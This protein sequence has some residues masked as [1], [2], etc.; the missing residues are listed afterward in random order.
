MWKKGG[1]EL[2]GA[3]DMRVWGWVTDV[4]GCMLW[5]GVGYVCK[6][7]GRMNG[8]LYLKILDDELQETITYYNKTKDDIIFQQDNDPKYTCKRPESGSKTMVLLS[9]SGQHN[10]QILIPLRISGIT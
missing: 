6:I 5:D 4:W 3:E 9:W 8:N 10:L 2:S 7:Y 1:E